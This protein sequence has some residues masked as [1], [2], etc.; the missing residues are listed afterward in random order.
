[1]RKTVSFTVVHMAVAFTLGW[2][3]TGNWM[4]GGALAL[5]EPLVNGA[6]F[7]VHERAWRRFH[8]AD[9]PDGSLA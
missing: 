6:A 3:F 4:A 8:Q 2:L 7:H 5:V 1:M 9:A